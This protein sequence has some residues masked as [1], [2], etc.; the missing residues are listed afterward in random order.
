[1]AHDKHGLPRIFHC[2]G[3]VKMPFVTGNV[4]PG[5]VCSESQH[6]LGHIECLACDRERASL[7]RSISADSTFDKAIDHYIELRTVKGNSARYVSAN[8]AR[9]FRAHK[10]SLLLFFRGMRL[11]DIHWFHLRAYQAARTAGT[12]P[13]IR[14]IRPQDAKPRVINGVQVP[15]K[16]KAPSPCKPQQCNQ[17]LATLKKLKTLSGCWT[18]EDD[19][20]YETLT[21]DNSGLPRSLTP[22]QQHDWLEVSAA[23]ERW[24]VVHH[25]CVVAIDATMSPNE[26]DGLRIGDVNLRQRII[27][28]PWPCAKNKYRKRTIAIEDADCLW[29]LDRLLARAYDLGSSEPQNYLFPF[30]IRGGGHD[31]KRPMTGSGLKRLWQEV[32][33]AT[34]LSWVDRYGMRHTGATRRAENGWPIDMIMSRM[35]HATEEMRQHYTQIS[36]A[37]Q[38]RWLRP[39]LH[40]QPYTPHMYAPPPVPIQQVPPIMPAR[41]QPQPVTTWTAFPQFFYGNQK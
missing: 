37:A 41:Q 23:R 24:A 1:M 34:H 13:F 26:E 39:D 32:R 12:D 15:A 16:G 29:S 6:T 10:E 14:Y 31:P 2:K 36:I 8:T 3:S 21:P 33:D 25:W 40:Q 19:A 18:A 38:R 9:M 5:R 30:G 4:Q 35:G 28:V 7:L 11:C 20:Y 22:Q 17:E 27:T